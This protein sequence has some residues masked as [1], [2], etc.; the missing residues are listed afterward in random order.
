L[1]RGRRS[2]PEE[3]IGERLRRLRRE[4]GLSQRELATPG[5][6]YAY[7]SRIEANARRPSVKALRLLAPKLGVTVEYLE[8]GSEVS[9]ADERELRLADAELTL[10]LDVEP[11]NA[12]AAFDAVLVDSLAAGDERSATRARI[13]LGLVAHQLGHHGDAITQLEE[14]IAGGALAAALRPDVFGILGRSYAAVGELERAIELFER[15]LQETAETEPANTTTYARYASNLSSALV[16][17]DELG[18]AADVLT[19]AIE[20]AGDSADVYTR[21][22]LYWSLARLTGLGGRSLEALEYARRAIALLEATD[23]TLHLARAYVMVAWI[24]GSQGKAEDALVHLEQAE[25]MFGDAADATDLAHLEVER[26][27]MLAQLG[28]GAE[29]VAQAQ[30]AIELLGEHHAGEQGTAWLALAEG[31]ALEHD[32]EA[33]I[34]A[35]QKAIVI[36][37]ASASWREA[38]EASRRCAKVLRESGRDVEALDMLERATDLAAR[39]QH[40]PVR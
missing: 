13:G 22:R 29:A 25:R 21:I 12:R 23:D 9:D 6:S 17:A 11:E 26:A 24:L 15:C 28:R 4:R 10:R 1:G 16:D 2:G 7:V 31:F 35:F 30:A 18:R 37:E 3:T 33:A 40:T 5:V 36:L 32:V 38:A 20:R 19:D 39:T 27:R 8:T 34:D 14:A